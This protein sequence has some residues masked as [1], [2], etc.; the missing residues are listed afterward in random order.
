MGMT[1]AIVGMVLVGAVS[2]VAKWAISRAV[3][4]Y[5]KK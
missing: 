2:G 3:L 5:F 1:K 4:N